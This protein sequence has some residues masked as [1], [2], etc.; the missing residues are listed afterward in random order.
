MLESASPAPSLYR[1][2]LSSL[3]L[4]FL[5]LFRAILASHEDRALAGMRLATRPLFTGR[6]IASSR[7]SLGL[8]RALLRGWE[9]DGEKRQE[10]QE[11]KRAGGSKRERGRERERDSIPLSRLFDPRALPVSLCR[12][13]ILGLTL[14]PTR[15]PRPPYIPHA[16]LSEVFKSTASRRARAGGNR[17]PFATDR[18]IRSVP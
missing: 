3:S 2:L 1:S 10:E 13:S 12:A 11:R 9:G 17:Y 4:I 6:L 15:L 8:L 18:N 5:F 14:W 7:G 16:S